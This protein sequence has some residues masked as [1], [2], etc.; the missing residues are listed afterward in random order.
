VRKARVPKTI[1]E[2]IAGFPPDVQAIMQRIRVTIRKAAPAATEK[3]SY[4]IPTFT[5]RGARRSRR[6]G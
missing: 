4:Q 2:Y 3:I 5:L 1:D 6:Q